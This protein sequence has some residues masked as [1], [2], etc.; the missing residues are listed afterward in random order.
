MKQQ[1]NDKTFKL[2]NATVKLLASGVPPFGYFDLPSYVSG[3]LLSPEKPQRMGQGLSS[4]IVSHVCRPRRG[5]QS[6]CF[7][8]LTIFLPHLLEE[9]KQPQ[10]R[11]VT[12]QRG[13]EGALLCQ[14]NP[15]SWTVQ[16]S[17]VGGEGSGGG[18]FEEL[19]EAAISNQHGGGLCILTT[20]TAVLVLGVSPHGDFLVVV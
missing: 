10:Q 17:V 4:L 7:P 19:R 6:L 8:W 15:A 5:R 9:N 20:G 1:T 16:G 13:L 11:L 3:F 12:A 18:I 14:V 2:I